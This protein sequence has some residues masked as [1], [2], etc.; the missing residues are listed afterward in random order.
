MDGFVIKLELQGKG[1]VEGS[2]APRPVTPPRTPPPP[3]PRQPGLL[4][5]RVSEL[6]PVTVSKPV[7]VL[8]NMKL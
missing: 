8:I 7:I 5:L 6:D 3:S 4:I 2:V 1:L